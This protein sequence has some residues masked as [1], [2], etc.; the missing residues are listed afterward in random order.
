MV[1]VFLW[2]E[3]FSIGG[4]R[5]QGSRGFNSIPVPWGNPSWVW[6]T[7]GILVSSFLLPRKLGLG[8]IF[9]SHFGGLL[10]A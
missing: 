6:E 3:R 8:R 2:A 10:G 1:L 5:A 7:G 9:P 4:Y